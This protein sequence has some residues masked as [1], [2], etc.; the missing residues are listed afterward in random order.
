[1]HAW[2]EWEDDLRDPDEDIKAAWRE[3]LA[4]SIEY[5]KYIQFIFFR[6]WNAIRDYAH[7]NGIKIV[8]DIPIFVALDSADVWANRELFQL[9]KDGYPTVVAGVPPDYFS[10]TGQLW[11]N[12]LY[13]WDYH[14]KTHYDWW[15]HRI[16][17]QLNM[18]DY[19]RVD[20][21]RGF[22][23]YYAIPYGEE[24][25]MH[26]KWK[27]GPNEDLFL[28]MQEV[29]GKDLPIWAEDLGSSLLALR[30]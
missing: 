19:I 30:S 4:D 28:R 6:Q 12:P 16:K 5:Y 2:L 22:E 10:A 29:F 17:G 23:Q 27:K 21:F 13:D 20:H 18:V 8:G 11:G 1:M 7:V 9:E 26:G 14:K 25:A 3:R 24:T 15:M